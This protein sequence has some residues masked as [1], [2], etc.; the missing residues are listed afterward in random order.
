MIGIPPTIG[1]MSKYYLVLGAFEAGHWLYAAV[2]LVGSL[3]AAVYIWKFIE[4]AYFGD[5]H[6][7]EHGHAAGGDRRDRGAREAPVSMLAPVVTL[8]LLCLI[9]GIG[10]EILMEHVIGP[11]V[12]L[13]LGGA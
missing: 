13:L 3:L 7:E 1:F 6:G 10:V 9:L 4:V 11:A 5:S 12:T 2:L 8:A